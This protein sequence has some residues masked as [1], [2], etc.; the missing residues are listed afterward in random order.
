MDKEGTSRVSQILGLKLRE[1]TVGKLM[2]DIKEYSEYS[3]YNPFILDDNGH[4]Q[5][6]DEWITDEMAD[7]KQVIEV[8]KL[9]ADVFL[10][11]E[12]ANAGIVDLFEKYDWRPIVDK[13]EKE[14]WPKIPDTQ[15]VI[16]DCIWH[17]SYD[18]YSGGYEYDGE[19]E[20]IGYMNNKLEIIKI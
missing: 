5:Y 1:T 17:C 13:L 3:D 18:H 16:V 19:V 9:Y 14:K 11:E 2:K 8:H 10:E 7:D 20:V 15:R 12:I 6:A 4:I